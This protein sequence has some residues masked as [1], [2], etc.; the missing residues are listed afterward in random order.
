MLVFFG[1]FF[2]R[3]HFFGSSSFVVEAIEPPVGRVVTSSLWERSFWE[4][5]VVLFD[6]MSVEM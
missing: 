1:A 3:G 4:V 5:K 6:S 2:K